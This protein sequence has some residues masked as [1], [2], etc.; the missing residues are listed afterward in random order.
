VRAVLNL[1]T[2]SI[3]SSANYENVYKSY[4]LKYLILKLSGSDPERCFVISDRRDP[5]GKID[6]LC[7]MP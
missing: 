2:F 1:K 6:E 3:F 7:I 4:D 5:V